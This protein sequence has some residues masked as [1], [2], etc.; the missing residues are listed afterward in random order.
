MWELRQQGFSPQTLW[1]TSREDIVT[2]SFTSMTKIKTCAVHTLVFI[3][4]V[5]SEGM[6]ILATAGGYVFKSRSPSLRKTGVICDQPQTTSMIRI[7]KH[8]QHRCQKDAD[9]TVL[10]NTV[11]FQLWTHNLQRRTL[12]S[13]IYCSGDANSSFAYCFSSTT[14]TLCAQR[15]ADWRDGLLSPPAPG[16]TP[17]QHP[18]PAHPQKNLPTQ[19]PHY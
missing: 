1:Y 8:D 3:E 19:H 4:L 18:A 9:K 17:E 13:L 12:H 16:R 14:T 5:R 10:E 6:E 11:L 7:H 15:P 2:V